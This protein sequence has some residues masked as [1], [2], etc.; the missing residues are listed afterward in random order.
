[1]KHLISAL[2][3]SLLLSFSASAR[4]VPTLD[5]NNDP[6]TIEQS[7]A[8]INKHPKK[9]QKQSEPADETP[10]GATAQCRDGSFSYSQN[11][12]GSCSHHGG[13]AQ[14]L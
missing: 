8:P 9:E 14:W 11:H 1:M 4:D 10:S 13:V 6:A 7:A 3:V 5:I 2:L 12:R